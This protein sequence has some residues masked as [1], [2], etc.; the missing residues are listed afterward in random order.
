[1]YQMLENWQPCSADLQAIESPDHEILGKNASRI[2]FSV[3]PD[4]MRN[5]TGG[6]FT[7][8]CSDLCAV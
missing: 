5:G 6:S 7:R 4:R 3:L 1:M 8:V 2:V